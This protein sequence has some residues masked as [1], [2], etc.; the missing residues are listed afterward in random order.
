LVSKNKSP[1]ISTVPILPAIKHFPFSVTSSVAKEYDLLFSGQIIER[2]L[3][4][5]FLEVAAKVNEQMKIKVLVVGDGPLKGVM[6]QRLI[7][8]GVDFTFAGYI[9]QEHLQSYYVKSRVLLFPTVND[10][11]GIVANEAISAGVPVIISPNAGAADDLI[12]SGKN[13]FVLEQDSNLW[14]EKS[15]EILNGEHK[16]IFEPPPS[17]EMVTEDFLESI[18]GMAGR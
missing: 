11:W 16:F 7:D 3:P 14:A 15:L 5:F 6:E 9:A 13:G 4:F 1:Q 12:Q 10:P 18:N 8:K 2:K 17:V